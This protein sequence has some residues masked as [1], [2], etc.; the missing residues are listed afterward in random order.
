MKSTFQNR[1]QATHE[2]E[3][4]TQVAKIQQ[5]H[6]DQQQMQQ[7][8]VA[9]ECTMLDSLRLQRLLLKSLTT[10]TAE[11]QRSAL[12]AWQQRTKCSKRLLS[13][14]RRATKYIHRRICLSTLRCWEQQT[15]SE[16]R[17]KVTVQRQVNHRQSHSKAAVLQ[18]WAE[19]TYTSLK[20]VTAAARV[21]ARLRDA[22]VAQAFGRWVEYWEQ[23]RRLGRIGSRLLTL[24]LSRAVSTW[25]AWT[26]ECRS[27]LVAE[28]HQHSLAA[29]QAELD[30]H[31]S[32]VVGRIVARLRLGRVVV[33]HRMLKSW[34]D[35]KE[36]HRVLLVSEVRATNL[37]NRQW[38][39]KQF[40]LWRDHFFKLKH[41]IRTISTLMLRM[42]TAFISSSFNRWIYNAAVSRFSNAKR[43]NPAA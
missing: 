17:Y 42:R 30:T 8:L 43:F 1:C 10:Q 34:W 9:A 22:R 26:A 41:K 40:R 20:L 2:V 19:Q 31:K 16:I 35:A 13:V 23:L 36:A 12:E 14:G 18:S 4:A 33:Q 37:I 24:R 11:R 25:V 27:E 32:A 3:T 39:K 21:V 15:G 7:E 38:V 6:F 28:Q 29:A 5:L